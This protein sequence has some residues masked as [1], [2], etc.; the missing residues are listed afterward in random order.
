MFSDYSTLFSHKVRFSQF[1]QFSA[2]FSSSAA[3]P[4]GHFRHFLC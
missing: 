3:Y 2:K 4:L 1:Q